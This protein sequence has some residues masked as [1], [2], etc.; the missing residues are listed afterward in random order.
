M[1]VRKKYFSKINGIAR[2]IAIIIFELVSMPCIAS[3]PVPYCDVSI[4]LASPPLPIRPIVSQILAQQAQANS[5]FNLNLT[6][7]VSESP[8]EISY[9]V[10]NNSVDVPNE[11]T[12]MTATGMGISGVPNGLIPARRGISDCATPFVLLSKQSC[13]LHFYLDKTKFTSLQGGWGPVISTHVSWFW[14]GHKNHDDGININRA[15]VA[16]Q[17]MADLL[18]PMLLSPQILVTPIEQDGLYYDPAIASIVGVPHHIG[19]HH[20]TVSAVLDARTAEPQDLNIIVKI[21]SHD[22]PVFKQHYSLASAMP[23]HEYQVNLLDMIE[24]IPGLGVTNQV[25]FR[26]DP[27][28]SH[29][30]WLILDKEHPGFLHGHAPSSD[31]GQI[32]EITLIATSNSG[33]DSLPMTIQIPVAYDL[34]KKPIIERGIEL[35]GAAGEKFQHDFRAKTTDPTTDGSLKLVID[36]IK[37]E[38]RWLTFSQNNPVEL[39]GDVPLDVVGQLYQVTLHANTAVGGDSEPVT[40]PLQIAIDE[41]KTPRFYSDNPQLP[42]GYAGQPYLY[43]FVDCDDVIPKYSDIP[44]TVEL[45]KDHNN[46]DWLRIDDNKLI[47]DEIPDNLKSMQTVCI[48]IKNGPGGRSNVLSFNLIIMNRT[49]S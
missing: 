20:F 48:T 12:E 1:E 14:G 26:I 37:P 2:S 39:E 13:L 29:P 24:P 42:L 3:R 15:P 31:S 49:Q 33:G 11:T 7:F 38:A 45:A 27:A 47:V 35:N 9:R 40:I 32:K 16:R 28:Q 10:T 4:E 30:A 34:A 36:Q 19:I 22:T 17:S 5:Q 18:A 46:P 23:E 43:N 41:S 8:L 21:N 6:R 44:Y 25:D